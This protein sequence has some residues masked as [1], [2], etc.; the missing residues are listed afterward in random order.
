[1]RVKALADHRIV[2][3]THPGALLSFPTTAG[4][5]YVRHPFIGPQA[6][7]AAG[8]AYTGDGRRGRA[9]Q[10]PGLVLLVIGSAQLMVLVDTTI[11]NIALPHIQQD[12][13]IGP[14]DLSWVV[15]AYA[16]AIAGLLLLLGGRLG[17][18]VGRRRLLVVG[19]VIFSGASLIGGLASTPGVLIAARALQGA[20]AALGSPAA[21]ALTTSTFPPGPSRNRAMSV[22]AAM[23]GLG[24]AMGLL[25]GGA[26]TEHN[27]RWTF[28]INVPIGLLVALLAP[29]ALAESKGARRP[30]D[31]L[32]AATATGGLVAIVYGL[33]HVADAEGG[34]NSSLSIACLAAGVVLL[35]IFVGIERR[36]SDPLLPLHI[37]VDRTRGV[38]LVVILLVGAGMFAL[39]YFL[40]LYVQQVLGYTALQPGCA[41][42]PLSVGIAAAAALSST[43]TNRFDP[44]WI[45]GPGA[46]LAAGGMWG[47]TRLTPSS[48]F[49]ADLLPWLLLLGAGLGLT[50]VPL[51]LTAVAR[52]PL[53][54]SGVGSA[55]F[56]TAQQMGGAVGL[57]ALTTVFTHSSTLRRG[58]LSQALVAGRDAAAAS[59]RNPA[60]LNR[61]Q[62]DVQTAGSTTAFL[63]AAV[64][65]LG[66]A[67]LTLVALRAR[68]HELTAP[69]V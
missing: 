44:Q 67:L 61:I 29:V 47:F 21:L 53:D 57:A 65:I 25:L 49:A 13:A 16:L 66:A 23:S 56:N 3:V 4:H 42:L 59:G 54:D 30:F 55:S 15:N 60:A 33:T 31:A 58:E 45:S 6:H 38:S 37:L 51:I 18:L 46:L 40:S 14:S 26:L 7:W 24:A 17:D 62:L 22:Y 36:R 48:S 43:L 12:L 27:W 41:F 52:L 20:G 32:G 69:K 19:V 2:A 68:R 35:L 9:P 63:V 50:Y 34:W 39:Y 11:V 1:M 28:F 8:D 10:R 5:G 64:V